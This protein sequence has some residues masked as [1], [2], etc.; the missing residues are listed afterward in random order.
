MDLNIRP[1]KQFTKWTI[2]D[3]CSRSY[4]RFPPL[5]VFLAGFRFD[6]FFFFAFSPT[7]REKTV[8]VFVLADASLVDLVL[9]EC[10]KFDY[11][12]CFF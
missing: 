3:S 8:F 1:E 9:G 4:S 6:F 2:R 12:V 7:S 5:D 10:Y 11:W